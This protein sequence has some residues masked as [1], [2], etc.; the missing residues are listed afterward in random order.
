MDRKALV[1]AGVPE[2]PQIAKALLDV[3]ADLE[4]VAVEHLVVLALDAQLAFGLRLG[5]AA[6]GQQLVPA[7]DLGADEPALQ[8]GMD[9]PGALGCL[10]A[11]SERPGPA[12]LVAGREERPPPEQVVR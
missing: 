5:P 11:G 8:V 3:E 12:L 4:H 7:D 1:R 6:D 2:S 9:D 10:R